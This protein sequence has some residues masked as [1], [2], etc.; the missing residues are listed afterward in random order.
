MSALIVL[1]WMAAAVAGA[2]AHELAHYAVWL[3]SGRAPDFDVW[4]LE[5]VPTAG[6]RESTQADR[7][8]AAAPYALG[9]LAVASGVASA[10]VTSAVFGL[11]M[12]QV[13]S[14]ADLA[15]MRGDVEWARL[16]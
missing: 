16:G 1:V 4:Q 3:V 13:P 12:V 6:S 7:V 11:A 8:A 2:L 5:V 9:A 15:A 10:S 14:R